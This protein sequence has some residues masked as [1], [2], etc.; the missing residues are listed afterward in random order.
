VKSVHEI[1]NKIVPNH[2]FTCYQIMK[3][4]ISE[5]AKMNSSDWSGLQ[6]DSDGFT[7]VLSKSSKKML[8]KKQK[9]QARQQAEGDSP[10]PVS[11]RRSRSGSASRSQSRSSS[12]AARSRSHSRGSDAGSEEEVPANPAGDARE[13]VVDPKDDAP[14]EENEKKRRSRSSSNA[15]KDSV[16]PETPLGEQVSS[17]KKKGKARVIKVNAADGKTFEDHLEEMIR[18][19]VAVEPR[20]I[21]PS[22]KFPTPSVI[23]QVAEML[24]EDVSGAS[25]R[26]GHAKHEEA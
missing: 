3:R 1:I 24:I 11:N 4:K 23:R 8:R 2:L 17:G 18:N 22:S 25:T 16:V 26:V 13:Q 15:P 20:D 19:S 10:G 12:R 7:Q 5:Q 21:D 6:E 9:R 14:V